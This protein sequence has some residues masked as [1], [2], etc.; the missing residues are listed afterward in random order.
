MTKVKI[1]DEGKTK[2]LKLLNHINTCV[3]LA[4]GHF[5]PSLLLG[6]CQL[7]G[8][9]RLW[10][11]WGIQVSVVTGKPSVW[12]ELV[13]PFIS[14]PLSLKMSVERVK[15]RAP[16]IWLQ[17]ARREGS[18]T[19]LFAFFT[20]PVPQ[21]FRQ[22]ESCS[23]LS[24][25]VS[26]KRFLSFWGFWRELFDELTCSIKREVESSILSVPPPHPHSSWDSGPQWQL[27]S[28]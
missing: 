19:H 8:L 27:V 26:S 17:C 7:S 12:A 15:Q 24:L 18:S 3:F 21:S 5:S 16:S 25:L 4:T 1:S 20:S 9:L 2:P 23:M 28:G 6:Y 11:L 22:D 10:S 13:G 14:A